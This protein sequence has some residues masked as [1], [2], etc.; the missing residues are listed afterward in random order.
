MK[1]KISADKKTRRNI[2]LREA[3]STG[4]SFLLW[5][6]GLR[7]N[8]SVS[9]RAKGQRTT[10]FIHGYMNNRST[11]Y[12]CATYLKAQGAGKALYF[13]YSPSM[14]VVESSKALKVFLKRHVRGGRIDI[15]AHSLGGLIAQHYLQ[16]LG[17]DRRVDRC[18]TLG[19]PHKGTYNAYWLPTQVGDALRPGSPFLNLMN[20]STSLPLR[21]KF[22]SILGASDN[23]ILPRMQSQRRNSITIPNTGH[24]GLLWSLACFKHVSGL[25]LAP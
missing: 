5:P 18:I 21:T 22:T 25:L 13:D 4:A 9:P 11:L 20:Q 17:G 15:V 6:L 1:P 14:S 19:T 12:P 7:K 8:N 3:L 2:I 24:M 23:I 16:F 10:V